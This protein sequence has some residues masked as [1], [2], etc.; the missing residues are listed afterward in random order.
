MYGASVWCIYVCVHVCMVHVCVWCVY[1]YVCVVHLRVS[2]VH[3]CMCREEILLVA[4]LDGQM[5]EIV[6]SITLE[7]IFF[8]LQVDSS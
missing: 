7:E 6:S 2:V 5:Q 3:L 4:S 8:V 1:M